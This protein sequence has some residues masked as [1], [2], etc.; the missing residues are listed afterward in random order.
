MAKGRTNI[1][2]R[3]LRSSNI[4]VVVSI[5]LVLFLIGVTGLILINIQDY[6]NYLKEKYVIE[7][8]LKDYADKKDDAQ[9]HQMQL[10]YL[11]EIKQMPFTKTAKYIDKKTAYEYAKKDLG[12]DRVNI[13]E[14][15][16]FP[17]SIQVTV[18]SK[19]LNSEG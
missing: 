4:T 9:V 15:N 1:D 5:A 6:T 3:R 8:F 18:K 16:I 2:Q 19:Y 17:A 14:E 10:D 7:V 11:D 12:P 13:I